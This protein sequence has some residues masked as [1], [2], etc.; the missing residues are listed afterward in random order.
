MTKLTEE[1]YATFDR[2]E[3]SFKK[4]KEE[5]S[6]EELAQIK[7]SFKDIWQ[8]WKKV[9]LSVYLKLPQDKFA[10]V[11]VESWTNGWNLRDHYWAAYRLNTLAEKSPCIGV[12]LDKKQLQV[13]LMFQHYKSEKRGD[14]SE[15]YNKLLADIPTWA[16]NRKIS[17]WYLWDKNEMEFVDH[18]FL[19]DYLKDTQ[20]QTTFNEEAIKTSFLLGKFAFRN[21]D[22]VENMEEFILDGIKQLL[23]LYEKNRA[24]DK[25]V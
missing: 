19:N 18:L 6:E 11:H 4:L 14:S 1:M 12:M 2:D 15:Q 10:K 17:N 23:P 20:K 8:T 5:Y 25:F 16:K 9:N 13:Y 22:Q 24:L 3:F 21:Q 7:A